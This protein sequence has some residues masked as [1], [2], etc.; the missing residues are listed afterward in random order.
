MFV[1]YYKDIQ[2]IKPTSVA[3][4]EFIFQHK[5]RKEQEKEGMSS[6]SRSSTASEQELQDLQSQGNSTVGS[7]NLPSHLRSPNQEGQPSLS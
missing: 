1:L 4:E 2:N 3:Q 5:K 7:V 6:S